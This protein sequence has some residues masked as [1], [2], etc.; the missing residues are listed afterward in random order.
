MFRDKVIAEAIAQRELRKAGKAIPADLRRYARLAGLLTAALTGGG[1]T[2][3]LLLGYHYGTLY[4]GALLFMAVLAMMG[5]VQAVMG[6]HLIS[7]R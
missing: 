4:W 7:R 1:A 3:I 2:V 5:L 6:L